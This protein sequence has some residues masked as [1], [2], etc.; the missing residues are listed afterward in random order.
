MASRRSASGNKPGERQW[1]FRRGGGGGSG[2][3]EEGL[4]VESAGLDHRV[5][6]G[7]EGVKDDCTGSDLNDG[8]G[9][10][11]TDQNRKPSQGS[12]FR[13]QKPR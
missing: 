11:A 7:D 9:E 5:G 6:P 2:D 3:A 1:G 12:R 4:D 8:V 13:R 10:I